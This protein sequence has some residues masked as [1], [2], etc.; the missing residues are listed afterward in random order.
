MM[1]FV[2]AISWLIAQAAP[3]SRAPEGVTIR[4]ISATDRLGRGACTGDR[5][6]VVKSLAEGGK[7]N[8]NVPIADVEGPALF[9]VAAC[10][11]TGDAVDSVRADIARLLIDAQAEVARPGVIR[12][13]RG[14]VPM[15]PHVA[16]AYMRRP[17]VLEVLLAKGAPVD[18][19]DYSR[20]GSAIMWAAEQGCAECVA[21]LEN[22]GATID[23]RNSVG[24]TALFVAAIRGDG[25]MV[26]RLIDAGASPFA[27]EPMGKRVLDVAKTDAIRAGIRKAQ[28][29]TAGAIAA[30][31]FA[32]FAVLGAVWFQ[33]RRR[34][35]AEEE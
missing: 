26:D 10:P 13:E 23:R 11:D 3:P 24:L 22:H 27:K 5:E 30:W 33:W 31:L 1:G 4:G 21:V 18:E 2:L 35:S 8:A 34:E 14:G 20:D 16:A 17:K 7:S 19:G 9:L 25:G 32:A 29:R 28:W 6:L 12:F 15:A